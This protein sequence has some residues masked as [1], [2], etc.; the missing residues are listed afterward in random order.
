MKENRCNKTKA[1]S[2]GNRIV[3][4]AGIG[5]VSVFTVGWYQS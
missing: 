1:I 4:M 3:K 5:V 2:A